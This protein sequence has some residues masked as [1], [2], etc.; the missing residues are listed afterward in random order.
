MIIYMYIY[1]YIY[2]YIYI[3]YNFILMCHCLILGQTLCMVWNHFVTALIAECQSGIIADTDNFIIIVINNVAS[4]NVMRCNGGELR[5]FVELGST[6]NLS[7][8]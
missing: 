6:T 2:I 5:G 1:R 7:V 3:E 4:L 8:T